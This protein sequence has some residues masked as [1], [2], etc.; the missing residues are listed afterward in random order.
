MPN[1]LLTEARRNVNDEFYTRLE[2]IEM[3]LKHYK[4]YFKGK[5]VLCNCDDPF[6]SNFFKYFALNFN[7]F[8]LKKL[9][10]TCYN[11]SPIAGN[12]L[13]LDFG[14]KSKTDRIAYKVELKEVT[15]ITGDGAIDMEDIKATLKTVKVVSELKGNGDFRSEECIELLKDADIVVTNPPFSLF[16]DFLEL[17]DKYNKHF[18]I[19]G[20][21]NALT[22]KVTFQMFKLDKIRTGYTHFN[23]G[24]FFHVPDYFKKYHHI[25]DGKKLARVSTS[26][27]YTNLPVEKHKEELILY[28]H[29]T[30]EDYP[31]YDNYDAIEVGK[32]SD[33]PCDYEGEIGV[34][35][36]FLDKFNPNQFEIIGSFNASSIESKKEDGYVLS[37]DTPTISKGKEIL[38]NGP[39]VN[40]RPL[41]KRIV[42]RKK[43]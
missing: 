17:L 2:D 25:E 12:E 7:S 34:P 31:H 43:K 38:W 30:P 11:G 20:N 9:T 33:I 10:A 16:R 21:T 42:I 29:Y 35:I 15:D 32:Y 4:D 41:Y 37:T 23:T 19:I 13:E 1:E 36:T 28:K 39:V 27:W 26:C 8:G 14:E 3:E 5:K 40:K 18:I 22:Y 6:E 24:M